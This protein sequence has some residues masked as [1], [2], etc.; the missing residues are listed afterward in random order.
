MKAFT[1]G[2]LLWML[3]GVW[4]CSWLLDQGYVLLSGPYGYAT[5]VTMLSVMLAGA[6]AA[7]EVAERLFS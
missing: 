6:F 4:L 5:L 7:G 2:M 3:A 1:A